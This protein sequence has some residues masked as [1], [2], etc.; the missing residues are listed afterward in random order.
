MG[1][2]WT[3]LGTEFIA[4]AACAAIVALEAPFR[5]WSGRTTRVLVSGLALLVTALLPIPYW[6]RL[7]FGQTAYFGLLWG[8]GV[9]TPSRIAALLKAQRAA[10]EGPD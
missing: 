5:F 7:V 2:A 10:A 3:T 6:A 4:S 9:L 8:L 1:A